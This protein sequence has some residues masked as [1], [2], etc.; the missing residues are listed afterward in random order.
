M[1]SGR[2]GCNG[3]KCRFCSCSGCG[4]KVRGRSGRGRYDAWR[5]GT[6]VLLPDRGPGRFIPG[7]VVDEVINFGQVARILA[8][9]IVY[10]DSAKNVTVVLSKTT[11]KIMS[12]RRV[13]P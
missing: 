6:V 1:R 10:Y 5:A 12:A 9:R 8:D 2:R 4:S 11:G 3:I 7:S 13:S